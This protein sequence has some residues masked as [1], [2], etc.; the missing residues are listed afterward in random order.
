VGSE[1]DNTFYNWFDAAE[2]QVSAS[3]HRKAV[4]A[5][6][7]ACLDLQCGFGSAPSSVKVAFAGYGTANG[8]ALSLQIPCG[9]GD[10]NLDANEWLT[11]NSPLLDV[12]GPGLPPHASLALQTTNPVRHAL[13]ATLVVAGE[14]EATIDVLDVNGRRVAEL[15]AGMT[16]GTRTLTLDTRAQGMDPGVYFVIARS[17]GEQVTRRVVVLR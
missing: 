10:G 12:G 8:A 9:N 13:A 15:F 6:L 7:E 17:G 11:V 5:V 4:G 14:H 2:A 16:T 3:S 1:N